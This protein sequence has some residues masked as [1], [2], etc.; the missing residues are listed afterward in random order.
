MKFRLRATLG[1]AL[2]ACLLAA[3]AA[4]AQTPQPGP[5]PLR[6]S[7]RVA[8]GA[9]GVPSFYPL[10]DEDGKGS[11]AFYGVRQLPSA[12]LLSGPPVDTVTVSFVRAGSGARIAVH[13]HRGSGQGR[14]S[15]KVAECVPRGAQ[16]TARARGGAAARGGRDDR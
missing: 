12:R 15:I 14:E 6:L 10:P 2:A 16:D 5:P 3:H 13:A 8:I 7:V 4:S 11:S 9:S 1:P